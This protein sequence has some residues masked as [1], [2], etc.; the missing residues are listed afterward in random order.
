MFRSVPALLL[1]AFAVALSVLSAVALQAHPGHGDPANH[2][3]IEGFLA[4]GMH[5]QHWILLAAVAL[6]A[7]AGIAFLAFR[8]T[9]RFRKRTGAARSQSN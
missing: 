2:G 8:L 6:A 3:Y 9:A 1:Q 7:L 5:P 4:P